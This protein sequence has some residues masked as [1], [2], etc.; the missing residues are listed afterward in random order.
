MIENKHTP[1]P[2][3]WTW[4]YGDDEMPALHGKCDMEDYVL[5]TYRCDACKKRD[6]SCLHPSKANARL[7]AAAP[8]LLEALEAVLPR[9]DPDRTTQQAIDAIKKAKGESR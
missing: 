3:Q 6:A 9:L 2:W 8:D 1:G 5:S 4:M 7:I